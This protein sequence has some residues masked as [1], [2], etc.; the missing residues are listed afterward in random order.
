MKKDL[1]ILLLLASTAVTL[2]FSLMTLRAAR[3]WCGKR[4]SWDASRELA[5]YGT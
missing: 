5:E 1:L 2:M 3:C 4:W